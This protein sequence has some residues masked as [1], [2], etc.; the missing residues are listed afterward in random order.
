VLDAFL[1][2]GTT[3]IAAEHTGRC[4][5]ALELDPGNVDT[6]FRRWQTLTGDQARNVRTVRC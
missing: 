4:C 5:Y 3:V 2:G 1:G 6:A